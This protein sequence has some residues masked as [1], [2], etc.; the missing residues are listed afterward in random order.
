MQWLE[1][2]F[3]PEPGKLDELCAL[4]EDLGRTG[5][6]IEDGVDFMDF[7]Q[8]NRQYWDYADAGLIDEKKNGNAIK[9]YLPDDING[10]AELERISAEAAGYYAGLSVTSVR[11][12]DWETGWMQYYKP[13]P[14]GQ[15]LLIVPEWED[16]P[17]ETGRTVLRLN[18]GLI[19][20]TG[21]HPT[22]AMCLEEL[23][24][25]ASGAESVLDLGCGSGILAIASLVLGAK[26]ALG[27]DIDPLAPKTVLSNAALNGVPQGALTVFSGDILNDPGTLSKIA[28]TRYDLILMNIVADAIIGFACSV[29]DLLKPDGTFICSGIIEGRQHEV[30]S[31]ISRAGLKIES[32]RDNNGWH[33]FTARVGKADGT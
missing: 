7:L 11:D 20:G 13:I 19:F 10:Q 31:A 12:E 15:K 6:I 8:N 5:L 9:L 22:T 28:E 32:C 33:C 16:I 26:H 23:E 17:P 25:L 30:I 29:P 1:V 21:S 4:L 27:C 18:P 2:C 3:K 24:P 14:V